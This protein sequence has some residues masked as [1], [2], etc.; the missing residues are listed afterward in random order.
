VTADLRQIATLLLPF[1]PQA[2]QKIAKAFGGETVDAS[3]GILF[4]KHESFEA[5]GIG[6]KKLDLP[7]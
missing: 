1:L 7:D 3:I 5:N 4:P 6:H 2:A